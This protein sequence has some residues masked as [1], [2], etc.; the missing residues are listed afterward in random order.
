MNPGHQQVM[1]GGAPLG[2][3]H[4]CYVATKKCPYIYGLNNE[5]VNAPTAPTASTNLSDTASAPAPAAPALLLLL[6]PTAAAAP[7]ALPAAARRL[8]RGIPCLAVLWAAGGPR[9]SDCRAI[10][11]RVAATRAAVLQVSFRPVRRCPP[12]CSLLLHTSSAVMPPVLAP[13]S[14]MAPATLPFVVTQPATTPSSRRDTTCHAAACRPAGC[15]AAAIPPIVLPDVA[16]LP[17]ALPPAA[18][19]PPATT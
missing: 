3:S 6:A 17:A 19:F 12:R 11:P 9:A 7:L 2:H 14:V 13:T 5:A 10:V 8:L 16:L 18:G 15:C 1:S 4:S